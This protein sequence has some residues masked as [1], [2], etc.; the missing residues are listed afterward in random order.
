MTPFEIDIDT[1]KIPLNWQKQQSNKKPKS[2]GGFRVGD[3]VRIQLPRQLSYGLTAKYSQEKFK[4]TEVLD[5]QKPFMF[6][7]ADRSGSPLNQVW[8]VFL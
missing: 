2:D 4:V 1:Q 6:K 3:L 5:S 8:Y 7:L